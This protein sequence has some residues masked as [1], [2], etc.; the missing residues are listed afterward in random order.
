VESRASAL[1]LTSSYSLSRSAI[2]VS[3]CANIALMLAP[4][5][6]ARA[7]AFRRSVFSTEIVIFCFMT[8]HY[9]LHV[10]YVRGGLR[11]LSLRKRSL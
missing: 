5:C 7:R 1:R 4:R 8:L 2:L 11:S 9:S 3:S 6:D 10:K